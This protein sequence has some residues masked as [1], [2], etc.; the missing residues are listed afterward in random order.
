MQT[1]LRDSTG[2]WIE[3]RSAE[4]PAG[5]VSQGATIFQDQLT[6]PQ[7]IKEPS[8][9]P[10]APQEAKTWPA[11]QEAKTW[12][13][14]SLETVGI[15]WALQTVHSIIKH[16]RQRLPGSQSYIPRLFT[17][18]H[19]ERRSRPGGQLFLLRTLLFSTGAFQKCQAGGQPATSFPLERLVECWTNHYIWKYSH[20]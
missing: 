2:N 3:P 16:R 15:P 11:P 4:H 1:L 19:P 20:V 6:A 17:G 14:P 8:L 5:L 12:P 7:E 10:P 18:N 13:G 9:P